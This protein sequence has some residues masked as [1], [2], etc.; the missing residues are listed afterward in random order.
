[1]DL[2][3]GIEGGNLVKEYARKLVEDTIRSID[4]SINSFRGIGSPEC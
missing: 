2:P 4:V 3:C 1:M